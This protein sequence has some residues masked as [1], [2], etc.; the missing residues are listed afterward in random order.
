MDELAYPSYREAALPFCRRSAAEP[1]Q[2]YI[3]QSAIYSGQKKHQPNKKGTNM[4]R[5][6]AQ[7]TSQET[8]V[9]TWAS[10]LFQLAS[11]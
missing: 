10:N 9:A 5:I 1:P 2:W 4:A 11:N 7:P 3:S 8:Y 6:P